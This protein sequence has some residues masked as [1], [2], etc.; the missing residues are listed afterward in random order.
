[1]H[2][3]SAYD[4]PA[5]EESIPRCHDDVAQAYQLHG[6][7]VICIYLLSRDYVHE[8]IWLMSGNT[9]MRSE[10]T[11]V[12]KNNKENGLRMEENATDRLHPQMVPRNE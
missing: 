8:Y 5:Q 3:K 9:I 10:T 6:T 7:T 2:R 12:C 4:N 11:I 1:M